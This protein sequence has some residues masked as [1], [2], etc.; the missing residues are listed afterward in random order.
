M[1]HPEVKLT[2]EPG[3]Q[4]QPIYWG[5]RFGGAVTFL[6]PPEPSAEEADFHRE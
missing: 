5:E 2:V 4:H 3:V 6:F 1:N